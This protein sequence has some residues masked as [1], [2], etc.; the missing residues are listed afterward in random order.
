EPQR[1][2]SVLQSA[3]F[4]WKQAVTSLLVIW[5]FAAFGE[6][7]SYRGYLLTRGADILR[8]SNLAYFAA[9]IPSQSSSDLDIIIKVR[10]AC[11]TAH[12]LALCLE[13]PI[14]Y[15]DEIFGLRSL[16]TESLTPLRC[17]SSSW[18]GQI[19]MGHE[20]RIKA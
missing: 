10:R 19:R 9:M 16:H 8:R 5:T 18:A 2:S 14:C 1:V 17:L 4:G 20:F 3:G 13:P 11:S 15:L 6:E 12:I 7:L